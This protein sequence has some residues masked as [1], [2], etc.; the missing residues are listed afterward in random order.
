[1]GM[2]LR[3]GSAPHRTR[4]SDLEIGRSIN[5]TPSGGSAPRTPTMTTP[6]GASTPTAAADA[7]TQPTGRASAQQSFSRVT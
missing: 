6:R 1:M 4:M 3:R 5:L 7:T 2:F